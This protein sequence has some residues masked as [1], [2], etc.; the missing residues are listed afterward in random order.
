MHKAL[1]RAGAPEALTCGLTEGR[2]TSGQ[3]FLFTIGPTTILWEVVSVSVKL[4]LSEKQNSKALHKYCN[5]HPTCTKKE[6]KQNV[7]KNSLES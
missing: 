5:E 4:L 7:S 2:D 6:L 3:H 1:D